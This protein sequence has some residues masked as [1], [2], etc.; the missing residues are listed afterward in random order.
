[1]RKILV[2]LLC[3]LM[4]ITFV[5]CEEE[6]PAPPAETEALYSNDFSDGA[7][8]GE[9]TENNQNASVEG[10]EL[11]VSSTTSGFGVYMNYGVYGDEVPAEI[12]KTY[13]FTFDV[14]A[15]NLGENSFIVGVCAGYGTYGTYHNV[16]LSAGDIPSTVTVDFEYIS[17]TSFS[18]SVNGSDAAEYTITRQGDVEKPWINFTGYVQ[19][20]GSVLVDNF[21]IVE[22][23]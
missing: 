17:E 4:L 10:G 3:A 2:A 5:A 13:R 15:S 22:L 19:G 6:T 14:D 21:Q 20:T 16:T 8:V 11:V 9:V 7:R 18:A 12:G 23:N 1:M